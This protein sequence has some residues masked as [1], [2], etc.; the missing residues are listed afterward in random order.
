[1]KKSLDRRGA[2]RVPCRARVLELSLGR[3]VPCCTTNI[4]ESGLFLRRLE[5]GVL[6]EGETVQLEVLLPG[7]PEPLWVAGEVVE[8][9]E[10]VMHDAAAIRFTAIAEA[11]RARI[12]SYVDAVRRAQARSALAGL[13]PHEPGR[14]AA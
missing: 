4:S 6:I 8:Q 7:D 10:E 1:M 13:S 5:G 12:R 9:V 2:R 14:A 3:P 11:D